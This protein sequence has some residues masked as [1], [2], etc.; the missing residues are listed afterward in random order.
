[1]SVMEL[2]ADDFARDD[3]AP[4]PFDAYH[5][6]PDPGSPQ[7]L[8]A[9]QRKHS[10][11]HTKSAPPRVKCKL[12]NSPGFAKGRTRPE[13]GPHQQSNSI[14]GSALLFQPPT[15]RNPSTG[16]P[17]TPNRSTGRTHPIVKFANVLKLPKAN[18]VIAQQVYDVRTL[19]CYYYSI[20]FCSIQPTLVPSGMDTPNLTFSSLW[21]DLQAMLPG[22]ETA[23]ILA[24]LA[25]LRLDRGGE[26]WVPGRIIKVSDLA[27]T[28]TGLTHIDATTTSINRPHVLQGQ[29]QESHLRIYT[30]P[31]SRS[32]QFGF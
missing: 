4:M 19:S 8:A 28:P 10:V 13:H 17:N 32:F 24:Y 1:M 3:D 5:A 22:E 21:F 2:F 9:S 30:V 14:T 16:V 23:A 18:M 7:G 27:I 25:Y 11:L 29:I 6:S 20:P 31:H 12:T 26:K 15:P